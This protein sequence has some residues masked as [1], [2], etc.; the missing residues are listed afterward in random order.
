MLAIWEKTFFAST[1]MVLYPKKTVD[2]LRK[3][4]YSMLDLES[5][6]GSCK[7]LKPEKR[8]K[9]QQET[10]ELWTNLDRISD[11]ARNE[12]LCEKG[13]GLKFMQ[14]AERG[15][16][17]KTSVEVSGKLSLQDILTNNEKKKKAL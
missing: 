4:K 6:I 7:V 10:V 17:E 5:Y 13:A 16:S 12:R 15:Y 8:T 3:K 14:S 1:R 9:L 11:V 2:A